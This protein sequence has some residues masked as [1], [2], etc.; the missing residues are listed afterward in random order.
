MPT[1]EGVFVEGNFKQIYGACKEDACTL[2]ERGLPNQDDRVER[3]IKRAK[4]A[5]R[6][7]RIDNK[8]A[9]GLVVVVACLLWRGVPKFRPRRPLGGELEMVTPN[10][11]LLAKPKPGRRDSSIVQETETETYPLTLDELEGRFVVETM[12]MMP[13]GRVGAVRSIPAKPPAA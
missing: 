1:M 9:V 7:V 4:D 2:D 3:L 13:H 10:E 11:G 8:E 5:G 12:I 6:E